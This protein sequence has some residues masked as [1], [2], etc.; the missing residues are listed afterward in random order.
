MIYGVCIQVYSEW[1]EVCVYRCSEWFEV[2]AYGAG[3]RG[4]GVCTGVLSG[5]RCVRVE[6]G[7]GVQHVCV[8]VYCVACGVCVQV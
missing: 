8:Q 3:D 1:S 5:L 2:C 6:M 7:T 4:T